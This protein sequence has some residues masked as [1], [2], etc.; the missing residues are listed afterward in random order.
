MMNMN[1]FSCALSLQGED[2]STLAKDR[3][4]T[5]GHFRL[6]I[7]RESTKP[8]NLGKEDSRELITGSIPLQTLYFI[9]LFFCF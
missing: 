2:A 5:V 6:G 1:S 9:M 8:V 3:P 4:F 7:D